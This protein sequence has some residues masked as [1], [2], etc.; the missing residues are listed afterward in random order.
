V[1]PRVLAANPSVRFVF[2][3]DGIYR[4]R[5]VTATNQMGL[6]H[7]FHFVGLV[8]PGQIPELLSAMDAVVHPSL[9]EGLARVLPQALLVGR[10]AISYD[11]DGA[12]E[13]ILPETGILVRPRDLDGLAAA[14]LRLA[15]DPA[16]RQVLGE[17]GRRRFTTQFRQETMTSQLRSL[18][19]RLL[20]PAGQPRGPA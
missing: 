7:A 12:R 8:P 18:Y 3:G 13:V 11:I 2:I 10:P 5:L 17:E 20:S 16:L 1:A 4:D 19:L 6:R 15:A 14:I 9:R